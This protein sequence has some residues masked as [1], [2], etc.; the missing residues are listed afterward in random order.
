[1]RLGDRSDDRQPEAGPS[2]GPISRRVGTVEGLE[3]ARHLLGREA[4]T[5][6]RHLQY[7]VI[8]IGESSHRHWRASGGMYDRVRQEVRGNL[9]EPSL[10]SNH[11][12][13]I[14]S[15][16]RD[17][18]VR[19]GRPGILHRIGCNGCEVDAVPVQR[20]ILVQPREQQQVLD[21][22][23]HPRGLLFDPAHGLGEVLLALVRTPTKQLRVSADRGERCPQL[24]GRVRQ[25]SAEAVLGGLPLGERLLDL[26]EHG[27]QG[28]PEPSDLGPWVLVRDP[29]RQFARGDRAG[30]GSDLLERPKLSANQPQRDQ[31]EA[32]HN[33]A[34]D[35]SLDDA[36]PAERLP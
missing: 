27:V 22:D 10:V 19:I 15:L 14:G 21:Q 6:V 17:L 16:E 24:M 12:H 31:S 1:M 18:P 7:R 32:E 9:A 2:R 20:T 11:R 34:G 23:S 26:G 36:E 4:R 3:R 8:P 13:R 35:Y 5:P 29:A 33:Q 30:R 25:E 28:Q